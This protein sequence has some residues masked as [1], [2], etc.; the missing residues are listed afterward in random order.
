MIAMCDSYAVVILFFFV[1]PYVIE[2]PLV[3]I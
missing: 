1:H 3:G 2:E